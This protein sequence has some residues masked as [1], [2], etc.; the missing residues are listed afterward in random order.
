MLNINKILIFFLYTFSLFS[1]LPLFPQNIECEEIVFSFGAPSNKISSNDTSTELEKRDSIGNEKTDLLFKIKATLRI[2]NSNNDTITLK[3]TVK[4]SAL[5]PTN[6]KVGLISPTGVFYIPSWV[7]QHPGSE[8]LS[9]TQSLK[10]ILPDTKSATVSMEYNVIGS[11]LFRY[12]PENMHFYSIQQQYESFYPTDIPIKKVKMISP[13]SLKYFLSYKKN[14]G[15]I[16]KDINISLIS[17]KHY[18]ECLIQGDKY[19]IKIYI[20]DTLSYNAVIKEKIDDLQRHMDQFSIYMSDKQHSDI[21]YINWRDDEN[22]RAFGESLGSYVV[23]DVNFGSKDLLHEIIHSFL[24]IEVEKSSKG[25]YFIKESIVEWLALF[26]SE[27]EINNSEPIQEGSTSLYD[28][29]TNDQY[30]WNEIYLY[31]PSIIEQIAMQCGRDKMAKII[32]SFLEKNKNKIANY[33][34]FINHLN[35]YLPSDLV[36]ELDSLLKAY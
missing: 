35:I 15:R 28:I 6:L 26:L 5:G 18:K 30:S 17:K 4:L 10:F 22:R 14:K 7:E 36:I 25:K 9:D 32:I 31:G 1:T 2:N 8:F 11:L 13:D 24:P 20:P 23:C 33:E 16:I 3:T 29:Q 34:S 12:Q 19:G 27:T 21:I